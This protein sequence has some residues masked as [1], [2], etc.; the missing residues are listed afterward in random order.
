MRI[1]PCNLIRILPPSSL[2]TL[3]SFCT[4]QYFHLSAQSDVGKIN[5]SLSK[6]HDPSSGK[7]CTIKKKGLR[8]QKLQ[9]QLTLYIKNLSSH[10]EGEL[11]MNFPQML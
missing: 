3:Q 7:N 9:T 5:T 1:L 4:R 2:P 11:R 6:L 10:Q 8:Q